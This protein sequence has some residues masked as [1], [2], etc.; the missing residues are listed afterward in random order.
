M[1][2]ETKMK[3]KILALSANDKAIE[4]AMKLKNPHGLTE[5]LCQYQV[6][7]SVDDEYFANQVVDL[8]NQIKNAESKPDMFEDF[9]ATVRSLKDNIKGVEVEKKSFEELE[10]PE[11]FGVVGV[12]DF[13]KD[14]MILSVPEE[15]VPALIKIRHNVEAFIVNLK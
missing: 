7:I 11:F 4:W 5:A 8:E 3:F 13:S 1:A 12:A 6:S 9:K 2:K 10:I 14:T 15:I